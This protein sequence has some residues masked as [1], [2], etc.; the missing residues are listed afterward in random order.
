MKKKVFRERYKKMLDAK[1]EK[2]APKPKITRKK[3]SKK[4]DK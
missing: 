4:G 1:V 3:A 2:F